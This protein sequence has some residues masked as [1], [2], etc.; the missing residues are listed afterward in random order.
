MPQDTTGKKRRFATGLLYLNDVNGGGTTVFPA[1]GVDAAQSTAV[2]GQALLDAGCTH[3][4][5]AAAIGGKRL[6]QHVTMLR[7][8]AKNV[9]AGQLDAGG[10]AVVPKQ[11][12]M[13]LFFTRGD[14]G[15]VDACSWHG[16]SDVRTMQCFKEVPPSLRCDAEIAQFV[17][18]RRNALL[19]R[20]SG[21]GGM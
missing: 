3:S 17:S 2:A 18:E 20:F 6:S 15:F 4:M 1:C 8:A 21:H 7:S 11:G 13:V 12:R 14:D 16:G 10:M 5:T 19:A 9:L